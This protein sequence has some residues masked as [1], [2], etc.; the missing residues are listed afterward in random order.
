[1]VDL[2][3][4]VACMKPI[5]GPRKKLLLDI[6]TGK[7]LTGTQYKKM[8]PLNCIEIPKY[9]SKEMD[10]IYLEQ[11]ND[12]TFSNP[13]LNHYE[14]PNFRNFVH[15]AVND[16]GLYNDYSH[17]IFELEKK[18]ARKWCDENGIMYIV[19]D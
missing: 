7:I 17:F 18:I 5:S 3:K 16:K 11:L 14:H 4:I 15:I 9:D 2:R 6:S 19:D 13:L 8:K 10:K 12:E 1:M